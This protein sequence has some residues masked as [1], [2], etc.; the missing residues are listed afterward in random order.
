MI[1][2]IEQFHKQE[3][4]FR[5]KTDHSPYDIFTHLGHSAID[6]EIGQITSDNA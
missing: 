3:G 1:E 6:I 2:E 5:S 4:H